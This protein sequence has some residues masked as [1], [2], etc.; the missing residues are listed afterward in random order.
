MLAHPKGM[1][2]RL[3]PGDACQDGH[4]V[5]VVGRAVILICMTLWGPL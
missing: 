3:V 1:Q 5:I 2:A 4:V